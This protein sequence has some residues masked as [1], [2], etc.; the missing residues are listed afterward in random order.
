SAK[1][2]GLYCVAVL[3]TH[4][5]ERLQEADEIVETIDIELVRRLLG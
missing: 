5:P 1:A 3:G 2:A 4:P